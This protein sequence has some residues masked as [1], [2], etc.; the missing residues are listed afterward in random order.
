EAFKGLDTELKLVLVGG[1]TYA[2]F[3]VE[4]LKKDESDR[5]L[6]LGFQT[7]QIL[8]ELFS[9]AYLYVLPSTIEGLSISLLEA[10]AYGNCVLTSDIPENLE[11]VEGHGF[12]FRTGDIR[13]LR[14][15]INYLLRNPELV[16]A[17]G[18]ASRILIEKTY[19]W[20]MIAFR[21]ETMFKDLVD[22]KHQRV[23]I[24]KVSKVDE[25]DACRFE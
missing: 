10:M 17:S 16:A 4:A 13:D 11:L 19:T 15:M 2:S 20:D 25:T 21:T 7:A 14:R 24:S 23:Q 12:T 1:S 8:E 5:I 3:Y 18:N 9:N 22:G 6:F